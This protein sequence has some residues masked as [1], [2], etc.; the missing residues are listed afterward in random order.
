M[1][2]CDPSARPSPRNHG[3]GL[4][5][6][7]RR[8]L[9]SLLVLLTFGL[10]LG[11][12]P[13]AA[14]APPPGA[15]TAQEAAAS[16]TVTPSRIDVGLFYDGSNVQIHGTAPSDQALAVTCVGP[17]RTLHLKRKGK[18]WGVLWMNV[19]EVSFPR[20]PSLYMLSTSKPIAQ[21][22]PEPE[23]ARLGIGYPGLR[24]HSLPTST[25]EQ[26]RLFAELIKLERHAGRFSVSEG[27]VHLTRGPR[28]TRRFS[29]SCRFPA[30]ALEG[31]YA[32]DL[33]GFGNGKGRVLTH[34][35]IR[36]EKVG[37][38]VF[39]HSLAKNHGLLYG[40]T[41]VIIA[42]AVGLITGFLFGLGGKG[43]H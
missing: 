20:I 30:H 19:G 34:R 2:R 38:A 11:A 33:I 31:T 24:A 15:A 36:V 10:P 40:I 17:D 12:S 25:P 26:R 16:L 13:A 8:P 3:P 4:R 43:A 29:A 18:V 32:V 7:L 27:G 39:I 14:S 37:T 9:P 42:L 28:G 21:L 23:R 5:A 35:T 41:A 6:P 22:A 1:I